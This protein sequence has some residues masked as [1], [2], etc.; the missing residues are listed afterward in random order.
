MTPVAL[1][2]TSVVESTRGVALGVGVPFGVGVPLGV[3]VPV[4]VGVPLGVGVLLGV[5]VP[6]GPGVMGT[7]GVLPE[8]PAKAALAARIAANADARSTVDERLRSCTKE[9]FRKREQ[10]PSRR[11]LTHSRGPLCQPNMGAHPTSFRLPLTAG[12]RRTRRVA[13]EKPRRACE[14][15]TPNASRRSFG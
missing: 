4:G 14:R 3:G 1:N 6:V 10:R 13:S 7:D 5:G 2:C 11:P 15:R 8:Q 9:A 12:R